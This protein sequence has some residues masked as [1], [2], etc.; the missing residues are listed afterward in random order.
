M[1][2]VSASII[3]ALVCG[4]DFPGI[5]D[6]S[7]G[8]EVSLMPGAEWLWAPAAMATGWTIRIDYW[9]DDP[10]TKREAEF[11]QAQRMAFG[12]G[13]GPAD[14]ATNPNAYRLGSQSAPRVSSPK[15][16]TPATNPLDAAR[17]QRRLL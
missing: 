14:N 2:N 13:P 10:R 6:S 11:R 1:K 7:Q 3:E 12:G 8:T 16:T 17:Q 4:L 15:P 9:A 5:P